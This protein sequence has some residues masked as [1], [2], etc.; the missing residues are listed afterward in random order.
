MTN[1]T[2]TLN[3]IQHVGGL[4]NDL[5]LPSFAWPGG[6]PLYYLT[7]ENTVLCPEHANTEGEYQDELICAFGI[8]YEDT[9]LWCEH[10][11]KIES[12]YGEPEM[13]MP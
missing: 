8:N 10:S 1:F 5:T 9:D 2:A 4:D 7:V 13:P 12:A 11:H 6:Y 3:L